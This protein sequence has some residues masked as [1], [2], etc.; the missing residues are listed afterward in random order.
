MS[1]GAISKSGEA[2]GTT[3]LI[4]VFSQKNEKNLGFFRPVEPKSTPLLYEKEIYRSIRL[5]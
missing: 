4:R 1:T 2:V 5:F 3:S